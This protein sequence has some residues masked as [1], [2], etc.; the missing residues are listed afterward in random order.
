MDSR[1]TSFKGSFFWL[2]SFG[3]I[4]KGKHGT[5]SREHRAQS[6]GHKGKKR[7]GKAREGKE[8]KGKERRAKERT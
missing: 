8:R 1:P 6:T 7:K 4:V 3:Q 5:Q 2:H